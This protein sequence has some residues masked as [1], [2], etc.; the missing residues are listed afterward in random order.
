MTLC[1]KQQ[2]ACHSYQQFCNTM[3]TTLPPSLHDLLQTHTQPVLI[4]FW[5]EWCGPCHALAPTLKQIAKDFSGKL[6]VI[7]VNIDEKPAIAQHFGITSIPTLL[8]F[9]NG[10]Q[11]W[12]QSGS[13]PY[14][15]LRRHIE[16]L[17]D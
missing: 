11:Q 8:L 10:K 6:T 16:P 4:D 12:R 1:I 3:E 2:N 5:A 13:M 17:I 14:T 9:K 7:K 15:E